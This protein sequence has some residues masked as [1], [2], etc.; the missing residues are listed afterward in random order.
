VQKTTN[1]EGRRLQHTYTHTHTNTKLKFKRAKFHHVEHPVELQTCFIDLMTLKY[2][3]CHWSLFNFYLFIY[4]LLQDAASNNRMMNQ[5]VSREDR[6]H[7][8]AL[9]NTA[10]NLRVPQNF[11][12]F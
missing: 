4:N 12:K 5:E 6:E 8:R 1:R 9:V 2:V 10:M 11:G 3:L 7:W